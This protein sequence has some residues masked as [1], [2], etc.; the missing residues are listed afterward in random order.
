MR[1]TLEGM[2]D[3]AAWER[4]GIE[5]PRFD[6]GQMAR[7]TAEA[8]QWLHFG[9]GNIFRGFIARLQQELLERGEAETGIVAVESFDYQIIDKIYRPCDNLT[10]LVTMRADGSFRREVAAGVGESLRAESGDAASWNRLKEIFRSPALKLVS[11]TITEKGYALET[12][13]GELLEAVR[14]DMEAGPARPV[15]TMAVAAA[16]AYE[17]Y[18]AGGLP[19]AFVSMD[20]C[21]ENGSRLRAAVLRIA[22]AWSERGLAAEGF[23]AYLEDETK[24]T[25]PWTMID[26]ITPHPSEGIRRALERDGVENMDIISTGTGTLTAPFVNT[27][28]KQYLV[29]EDRFPAGRPPLEKAG[30]FFA[31]RVTVDRTEKMKVGTCLNPLHTALAVFGCLL[32]FESI[33]EE[34]RDSDLKALVEGIALKEGMAAA[35]DP[36]IIRPEDFVREVIE[37]RFPNP[38]IPDTPQ[39]IAADTSQKIPVRFGETIKAYAAREDLDVKS[40]RLIPLVFAGWC[41][42]LLAIDDGGRPMELSPDPM[43]QQ[44]Q[45]LLEGV[46]FGT[47][48][49]AEGRLVPILSNPALFGENLYEIGLGERVEK[50]FEQMLRGPGCVRETLRACVAREEV[51]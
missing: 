43:A 17:R 15:H 31:D 14:K 48:E 22:R 7:R 32:G 30:V 23:A 3:R 47:P 16:L 42:Y 51:L 24:I 21:S 27:E 35:A 11:F 26:K 40:L 38:Y 49:S 50:L 36:G 2:E 25:F 34:M 18:L 13:G 10:L 9:A 33:A 5:L 37:E 1:L 44:L 8:P 46:I 29:V 19:L 6:V 45:K 28:E 39:R 12:M 41:R 4:A 20:N